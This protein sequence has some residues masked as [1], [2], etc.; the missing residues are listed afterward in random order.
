M[1]FRSAGTALF[2]RTKAA[3]RALGLVAIGATIRADNHSGLPFY[4]KMGFRTYDV[5]RAVP[6]GDGTPVD[7][8][9]KR[10]DLD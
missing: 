5:A 10:Y 9:R 6:L 1:L 3:A 7:R 2:E 8:I 4:E